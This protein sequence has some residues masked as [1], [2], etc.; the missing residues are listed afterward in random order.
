MFKVG[1]KWQIL[2]TESADM[3]RFYDDG[4]I[5]TVHTLGADCGFVH[6]KDVYGRMLI[7]RDI[8]HGYIKLV[9]EP[10]TCKSTI[11]FTDPVE[12]EKALKLIRATS[13]KFKDV[14]VTEHPA[15][16]P[17]LCR[18]AASL[19]DEGLDW[20]N[21]DEGQQYWEDVFE[22]LTKYGELK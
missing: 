7:K 10:V 15:V 9:E 20:Y 14:K 1:Q 3:I 17:E 18:H 6:A 4:D 8:D 5:F 11:E 21:T 2:D 19:I 22:K 13:I 12:F 16:D